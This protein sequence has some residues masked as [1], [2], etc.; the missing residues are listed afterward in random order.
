MVLA[1]HSQGEVIYWY[2]LNIIPPDAQRIAQLF[3]DVSGYT[4]S[5]TVG[6]VSYAGYKDWFIDKYR[7]PGFTIEVGKGTNP[8]P[9]SQFNEIY[10]DNI[11][12]LLLAAAV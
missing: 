8:L 7:R 4:L 3:S 5:Q 1:Y 10:N 2:Y 6:I 12:I 11:E 9:I